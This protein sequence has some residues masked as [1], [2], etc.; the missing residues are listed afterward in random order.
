[1]EIDVHIRSLTDAAQVPALA[2]HLAD[3]YA[4]E[5]G[6]VQLPTPD[7]ARI[8]VGDEFCVHRLPRRSDLESMV[9]VACEDRRGITLLTPPLTDPELRR[10]SSLFTSLQQRHPAAEIVVNDWGVLLFLRQ[11]HPSFR[12]AV[13]RLLNKGL[14]DPRL[15]SAVAAP[16][17]A[18]ADHGSHAHTTFDDPGFRA[19]LTDLRVSRL[20]RDLLPHQDPDADFPFGND[21]SVYFPYGYLTSGRICSLATRDPSRE[22]SFVISETCCRP[23]DA[24]GASL[25]HKAIQR[26]LRQSGNTVFYRY[27]LPVLHR[28]TEIAA[29]RDIRLVYQGFAI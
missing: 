17:A 2:E 26:P 15:Q 7:V 9:K 11:H 4:H 23:C 22:R 20:E 1:M 6:E 24:G 13:G 27:P 10:V 12:L 18:S 3:L 8:Y 21:T 14:K 16:S 28:L 19:S 29:Q 25:R 5:E